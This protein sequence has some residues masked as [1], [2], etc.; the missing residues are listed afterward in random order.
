MRQRHGLTGDPRYQAWINIKSRC[1]NPSHPTYAGYG[2]RG[3]RLHEAWHQDPAAF[4]RWLDENLGPRPAGHS[5]DRIDNDGHYEPGNLRWATQYDQTHNTRQV[6]PP[7]VIAAIQ[8]DT[9]RL[10][11]VAAALG[12][13]RRTVSRYR[14]EA[15]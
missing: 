7:E 15:R 11:D 9:R 13:S 12:V 8:A 10:D 5:L 6:T 4:V 14:A 1:L 2:G 3:I